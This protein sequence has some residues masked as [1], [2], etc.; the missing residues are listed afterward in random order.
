MQDRTF[1]NQI[2]AS[3][4]GAMLSHPFSPA[5]DCWKLGEKMF[6]IIGDTGH[7]VSVKTDHVETA[8]LLIETGRAQRAAYFHASWVQLPFGLLEDEEL[9]DRIAESYRLIRSALPKKLQ[10]GLAPLP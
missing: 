5:H 3:L 10:A 8:Q 1:V 2:C 4:P 6:A 9:R 7:A